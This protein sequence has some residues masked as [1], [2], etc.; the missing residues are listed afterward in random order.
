MLGNAVN[1]ASPAKSN[2]MIYRLVAEAILRSTHLLVTSGTNRLHILEC[3]ASD[4]AAY[5]VPDFL[6][7]VGFRFSMESRSSLHTSGQE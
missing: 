7:T 3:L 1:G 2:E 6:R 4:Q 5:Q